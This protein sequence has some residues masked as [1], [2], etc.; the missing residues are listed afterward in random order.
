M[1]KQFVSQQIHLGYTTAQN[2]AKQKCKE[3]IDADPRLAIKITELGYQPSHIQDRV[4]TACTVHCKSPRG[5][6]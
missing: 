2:Y 3:F 5:G 1:S 4:D 6:W